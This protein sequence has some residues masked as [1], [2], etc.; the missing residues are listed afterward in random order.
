M[1][2]WNLQVEG[3]MQQPL[4]PS[5]FGLWF[6]LYTPALKQ[7][8]NIQGCALSWVLKSIAERVQRK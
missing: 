5:V 6:F 8:F 4:Q 1:T 2:T 7:K 3:V